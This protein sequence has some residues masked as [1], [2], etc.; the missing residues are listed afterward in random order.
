M[1]T[2]IKLAMALAIFGATAAHAQTF[3]PPRCM[4]DQFP[5]NLHSGTSAAGDTVLL[6]WCDDQTS[7]AVW[8]TAGNVAG[9]TAGI[10]CLS[11]VAAPA[12]SLAWMVA[13]WAVCITGPMN[14]DQYAEYVLLQQQWLPRLNVAA[15]ANRNVYTLNADGSKGPQLVIG[16]VG[17]QVAPGPRCAGLRISNAGARYHDVSG[18]TSTDGQVLPAGSFALCTISF[19][20]VTG[21]P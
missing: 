18:M 21:W 4:V 3:S 20:P 11:S 2:I 9:V 7:L 12:W 17:E 16:A 6:L 19:P 1:R 10:G 8:G 13:A 15:G 14:A 5:G